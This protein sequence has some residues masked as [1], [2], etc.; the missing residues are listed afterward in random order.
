MPDDLSVFSE[1]RVKEAVQDLRDLLSHNRIAF[2][3][4]AGCSFDA[5][6]PLM[7]ELTTE[8]IDST[9][10]SK[11]SRHVLDSL[12]DLYAG[13][14]G[15]TIEDYM[16]D[17]VDYLSVADRRNARDAKDTSVELGGRNMTPAE[18]DT[19]LNEIKLAVVN[20]IQGR[21]PSL[22]NHQRFVR[23]IHFSLEAGKRPRTVD[24][25]VLNYDTLLEDA[26]GIEKVP[27]TDGFAGAVTGW[28]EPTAFEHNA[29]SARVQK[30][31]G[32]IDWCLLEGDTLPRRIRKGVKTDAQQSAV[33]IYPAATKFQ[34][35]QKDPF[36]QLL[37]NM[38]SILRPAN[39]EQVVLCIC[40]YGYQDSHINLEIE[41]AVYQSEGRL[42]VL[43][44]SQDDIPA[45]VLGKWA[46][47]SALRSQIKIYTENKLIQQGS[48]IEFETPLPWW[49]FEVLARVLGGER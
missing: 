23:S 30:V 12:V 6:L 22:E 15:Q 40:G 11:D 9:N 3:L 26:L 31:H 19:A 42:T 48:V 47:D 41:T 33:L 20:V 4:G 14:S 45:E 46:D 10:L 27:F 18:L 49:K 43:A 35:V 13:A 39:R 32:S 7:G 17:L 8:V 1:P 37:A 36:A 21:E 16:S 44:F 34:E 24:Y 29:I 5:G 28:W 25:F 38:R 2:L